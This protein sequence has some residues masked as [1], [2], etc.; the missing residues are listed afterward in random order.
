M[1][2]A[3]LKIAL[4]PLL[5]W[6]L[7]PMVALAN[8]QD[9]S[10]PFSSNISG[11]IGL[12]NMPNA[13][14]DT[15]GTTRAGISVLDPYA[16]GF[17]GV[18]IAKPLYVSLRQS[19]EM[20]SL[21]DDPARLYPGIDFKLRLIEENRSRPAVVL[22]VQSAAGHKRMGGEYVAA[23]KRFGNFDLTGGIGWGR[24]GS[25][26]HISNPLKSVHSHFDTS[27]PLDGEDPIRVNDWF[28]GDH[29]GFFGGVE[30]FTPILKGLSLKLDWG[31]DRQE[32]ELTALDS[33]RPAPWSA[34][35]NYSPAPWSSF[36]LAL[37]GTD[38][39]M[40]R[41]SLQGNA[42]NWRRQDYKHE[43]KTP[44]R[45]YR[46]GA[47]SPSEMETAALGDNVQLYNTELQTPY[48]A[49]AELRLQEGLSAPAQI[50]EAAVHMANHGGTKVEEIKITPR[51]M[52][53]RGTELRLMR[54]DL[55]AAISREEGSAQ[56][57]WRNAAFT[58]PQ[59]EVSLLH[60]GRVSE[61]YRGLSDIS[62][63]LKNQISLS[64]EDSGVLYRTSLSVGSTKP[65][66]YGLFDN[67]YS[68]LLNIKDNLAK[69]NSLRPPK[70]L[71]VRGDVQH[72]AARTFALEKL[73]T[74][75]TQSFTPALHMALSMGYLEEM[76]AGFGG[77]IL[78]RPFE[79]R[80]ALGAES[81]QAFKRDPYSDL[82]LGLN[83]DHVLS[84]HINAWYD[85]PHWDTTIKA[86]F[87]RYLA[88]DTGTTLSLLKHYTNGARLEGFITL[89]DLADS[90]L[91]GSTTHAHHGLRLTL[92]LGG[93][94]RAL[95]GG[96][97]DVSASPFGRDAGQKLEKP[98][99][100]YETTRP[101][102]KAHM[103]ENWRDIT[104]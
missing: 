66:R 30:Y 104:P 72:F 39:I 20:S 17:M 36:S 11:I 9:K 3:L 97:I 73:Y 88:E 56:E 98:F 74:S 37:Q 48:S 62:L 28:T 81:W 49:V 21:R 58:P 93:F 96:N 19:A 22:G 40:G 68:F 23:S 64:E 82:N 84:G 91:F 33:A 38:K 78:Y 42:A 103:I 26:G 13:R 47:A 4:I 61:F 35:F 102:T 95:R 99:D 86:S 45:P 24:F 70:V 80:F 50:S 101:F 46:S 67:G 29:V 6:V 53:L 15:L 65:V 77:E 100:L 5:L 57:I 31:A 63:K 43:H 18:Q 16:H 55:E 7:F 25:A 76:Y 44:L 14:M 2:P 87:G 90:D 10:T 8:T 85:M 51:I 12:N 71:P 54:R 83:G 59:R 94:H 79:L 1:R 41:I 69:L 34:G 92:P 32:A 89:S 52:G 60:K 75:Y 27:R